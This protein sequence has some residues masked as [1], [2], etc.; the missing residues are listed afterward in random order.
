VT[1]QTEVIVWTFGGPLA[2][3]AP[4]A[5]WA[6]LTVA[7]LS[8]VAWVIWSYRHGLVALPWRRRAVLC[9]LRGGV[10]VGLLAL[11]AA[12][13][14]VQRTYERPAEQRPLAVL[15]DR[16]ES[17][18]TPD[19][20]QRRR[21]DDA[22]RRWRVMETTARAAFGTV[23]TFEFAD[24]WKALSAMDATGSVPAGETKL[25]AALREVNER[26]PEGGWGA[27]VTLTDGLDTTGVELSAGIDDAARGALG[28]GTPLFF[29]P[30]RNRYAGGPFFQLREFTAPGRVTPGSTF[31]VEAT[32]DS[33]AAED[34]Q[35]P[36]EFT[37][38]GVRRKA[39][40]LQV[41]SG[42]RLTTWSTEVRAG[43]TESLTVE[44]RAGGERAKSIVRVAP[45]PTNRMLYFQG[46]LDWSYRF[47]AEILRREAAFALTPVFDLPQKD[48]V[49]PPGA[50]RRGPLTAEGLESFGIVILANVTAAQFSEEEQ[51]V[52][53]EW[54]RAGGVL[55]FFTPDDDSARGFSGSELEK[56]LP[57]VFSAQAPDT[58]GELAGGVER[59]LAGVRGALGGYTATA[60]VALSEFQW[61]DTPRVREIFVQAERR[62]R[63][64]VSPLFSEYARVAQAKPGAEVLAR[65]PTDTGPDGKRAILLA[66][67]RY[68]RGQ[69]GVLTTDALWRWRL[70]EP[71]DGR[72][73]ETF[74]Q[75]LFAWLTRER[76]AGMRFERPVREAWVER[77]TSFE[78]GGTAADEPVVVA[79]REG[80]G[81][82][83]TLAAAGVQGSARVYRWTPTIEGFWEITAKDEAGNVARHWVTVKKEG[84]RGERSGAAPDE[85]V[86]RALAL[87]T[88]GAVLESGS[89]VAWQE[90]RTTRGELLNERR[91]LLWHARW[92]FWTLLGA[93]ALELV[94]RR[95]WK[96]L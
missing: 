3:W 82:R 61:E 38:D 50:L 45:E 57:V 92:V 72:G 95:R 42:R 8:G 19:N 67:Q 93:Y 23:R 89:P 49:L 12:P 79:E 83:A 21:L 44:L 28:A 41:E 66:V 65:H 43:E 47:L 4:G 52:L 51:A 88:G 75:N 26:A 25:F 69:T 22:L 16:S 91:V 80:G 18:T 90:K 68:G 32:F 77:E 46:A 5:A 48:A 74:W 36:V 1:S 29:V 15:V 84:R 87:R 24:G 86:M 94:L 73:P 64:L 9:A 56:Q 70:A 58:A 39:E 27:V 34:R 54:V 96:L 7:A 30:G 10:W 33:F 20:R 31:R 17:M 6:V 14:R 13:T 55:L 11:L 53:N 59:R 62:D 76:Q 71:S 40:T 63:A 2:R 60:A 37:V 78:L 35:V 81:E 85:E